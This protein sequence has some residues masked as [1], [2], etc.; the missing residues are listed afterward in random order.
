MALLAF[1]LTG[2][3]ERSDGTALGEAILGGEEID[4]DEADTGY[5]PRALSP[6]QVR[7][8]AAALEEFP[9]EKKA[10]EFDSTAADKAGIY[11]AKHD[12]EELKEYSVQLRSFYDDAVRKGNTVL[13]W[14]E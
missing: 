9:I 12:P 11:V 10:R 14:I 6:A 5:G 3:V 8:V 1:M 7:S 13:L 4:G 2:N